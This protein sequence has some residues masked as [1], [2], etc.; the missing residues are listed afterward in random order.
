MELGT[1]PAEAPARPFGRVHMAPRA[2]ELTPQRFAT[3]D[4]LPNC[5]IPA[6]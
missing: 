1:V 4:L 3:G 5:P 2:M 6:I